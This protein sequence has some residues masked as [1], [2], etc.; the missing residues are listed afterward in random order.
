MPLVL[1][2]DRYCVFFWSNEGEPLEP[3]HVHVPE[4]RPPQS[5]RNKV[6][7]ELIGK[8]PVS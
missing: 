4:G 5:Q 6:T 7:I 3:F 1:R 2:I 8:E